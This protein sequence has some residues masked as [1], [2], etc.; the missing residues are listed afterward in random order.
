MH[1]KTYEIVV[2]KPTKVFF[3][4]LASQL[5]YAKLPNFR[6]LQIDNTAYLV[7][8][9]HSEEATLNEIE[10]YFSTMFHHEIS[11]WLGDGA[12]NKIETNFLDFLCCF[13]LEFH[14]HLILM[15]SS[16]E[17]SQQ[18]LLIKPR[19][20]LLNWIKNTLER[21]E[22]V[23]DV[24]EKVTLSHLEENSTAVVKNFSNLNDIKP[25]LKIKYQSL[26]S[27][28]MSRMLGERKQYPLIASFEDFKKYFSIE[29]HTQLIYLP[30]SRS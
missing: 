4:F 20:A 18:L 28:A 7:E 15:E 23:Q 8:K 12:R 14:N 5:A 9:K 3:S 6:L 2:L 13:K 19:L 16:I 26:F 21:Q 11:R 1:Q 25:F 30:N 17:K 10:K 29:I 22:E 27:L 24:I